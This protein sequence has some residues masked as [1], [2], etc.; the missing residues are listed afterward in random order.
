MANPNIAFLFTMHNE[1]SS[2]SGVV[3]PEPNNG[4]A[5]FGVNSVAHPEAITDGFYEMAKPEAWA[6]AFKIYLTDYW[7]PVQGDNITSQLLATKIAD[8]AY[9]VNPMPMV[10]IVQRAANSVIGHVEL[11]VDG[12]MGPKT[13]AQVNGLDSATLYNAIKGYAKEYYQ[14]IVR[15]HPEY[16]KYLQGWLNRVDA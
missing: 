7:R 4:K 2:L 6:Y 14:D 13:L 5:R 15:A 8:L 3:T 10:K 11:T 16:E 9:D 12:V 1:D